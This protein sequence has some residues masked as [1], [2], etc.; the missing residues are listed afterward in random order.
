[1]N[2]FRN[3]RLLLFLG[4]LGTF[5]VLGACN[6]DDDDG[7]TAPPTGDGPYDL[8]FTG[9]LGPH[10]GQMLRVLVIDENSG[11]I[12]ANETATLPADGTFAFDWTGILSDGAAYRIDF[13]ADHDGDGKYDEP[14]TD[15]AWRIAL[16]AVTGDV[17]RD[18]QHDTNF[19]DIE[20]SFE[21]D[22]EFTATLAPHAGQTMRLVVVD[23]S[24][25]EVYASEQA[26]IGADGAVSMHWHALLEDGDDY[27]IVFYADHNGNG[28][29]DAPPT[30]H[31]WRVE[32][33]EVRGPATTHF[34]HDTNFYADVCG[35]FTP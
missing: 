9:A 20:A 31:G 8:E 24:D 17:S 7:G 33:D 28:A 6:D 11:A 12:V 22:L 10:A 15:H 34:D 19:T 16:G 1:M 30:D 4:L 2:G 27:D 26:V 29:C 32:L 21:F 14:P 5:A 35:S 13:Y 23:D 25:G 18:F 3:I